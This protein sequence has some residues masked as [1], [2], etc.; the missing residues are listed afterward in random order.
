MHTNNIS[1]H[2]DVGYSPGK[3]CCDSE[4]LIFFLCILETCICLLHIFQLV[5]LKQH[6]ANSCKHLSSFGFLDAMRSRVQY[7]VH[8]PPHDLYN[9]K[10]V[11]E[12]KRWLGKIEFLLYLFLEN[13]WVAASGYL[14]TLLASIY[15]KPRSFVF[16]FFIA[17]LFS[18][19]WRHIVKYFSK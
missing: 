1:E 11:I 8:S 10:I 3:F 5:R 19:L 13:I 4:S 15:E 16:A 7:K 14:W 17:L 2:H 12:K 9:V 6:A 18:L